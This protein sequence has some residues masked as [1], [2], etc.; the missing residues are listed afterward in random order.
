M[1]RIGSFS[2]E[3]FTRKNQGLLL[4]NGSLKEG[5]VSIGHHLELNE[6]GILFE[7]KIME[8]REKSA[9]AKNK[10]LELLVEQIGLED[11]LILADELGFVLKIL[12]PQIKINETEEWLS[13]RS[14]KEKIFFTDLL[15]ANITTMNRAI[16]SDERTDSETK[17]DCLKWSNEL[18]HRIGNLS[19]ESKMGND[20]SFASDLIHNVK[21]YASESKELAGH[22]G[23]TMKSTMG[24]FYG[25][26]EQEDNLLTRYYLNNR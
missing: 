18:V 21:Q 1:T 10:N 3:N 6:K 8:L 15:L 4:F 7:F 13:L 9:E 26:I 14:R 16:W 24:R 5:I 11:K 12:A 19:F 22:L 20:E 25:L 17:I 2:V 23:A